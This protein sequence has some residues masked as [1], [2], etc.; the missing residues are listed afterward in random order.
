MT[1]CNT[2]T[3]LNHHPQRPI[4]IEF[5]ADDIS[6]DGGAIL[7]RQAEARLGLCESIAEL[8][9]DARKPERVVHTRREQVL[10]RAVQ[11]ALG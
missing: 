3:R 7:L 6:A 11:I 8:V 4:D 1:Q 5:S 10:Q 2:K 9:P